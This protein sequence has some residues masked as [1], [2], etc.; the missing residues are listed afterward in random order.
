MFEEVY[1]SIENSDIREFAETVAECIPDYFYQVPASSTQ[2]YHPAYACETPL[3]LYKHTLA[4]VRFINYTFEIECMADKWTSRERDL[5]RVA[6]MMHDTYKSGTESDYRNNKY[7]KHEHPMLAANAVRKYKGTGIIPDDEIEIIA[8]AIESHMG[9]WN[10]SSR[11]D[12]VLPKPTNKYQK[13]VH[14]ADYLASRKAIEVKFD[15]EN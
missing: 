3:G 4:L 8:N 15:D 5:V 7:T 6:G 14:W 13:I 9:M 12:V 1:N 10:T 2:K 11:S